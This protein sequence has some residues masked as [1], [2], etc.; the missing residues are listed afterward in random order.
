MSRQTFLFGQQVK[1]HVSDLSLCYSSNC[2]FLMPDIWLPTGALLTPHF[3][4]WQ[5]HCAPAAVAPISLSLVSHSGEKQGASCLF[6]SKWFMHGTAGQRASPA[7]ANPPVLITDQHRLSNTVTQQNV[8]LW[9]KQGSNRPLTLH[10]LKSPRQLRLDFN[11]AHMSCLT[12]L[13]YVC[14][15]QTCV[16]VV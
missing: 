14:A 2:C 4:L 5:P 10:I 9:R 15:R 3:S 6:W 7:N 11:L 1:N 8:P 16:C 13:N 12:C